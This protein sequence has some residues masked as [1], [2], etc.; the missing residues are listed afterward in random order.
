MEFRPVKQL[1]LVELVKKEIPLGWLYKWTH[2]LPSIYM[3]AFSE[4]KSLYDKP[5]AQDLI[6]YARRAKAEEVLRL[7]SDGYP[8]ATATVEKNCAHN[9]NYTQVRFGTLIITA[10]HVKHPD[11]VVRSARFRETLA[12]PNLQMHL[13]RSVEEEVAG[14]NTYYGILLHGPDIRDPRKPGFAY[15][16]FPSHDSASYVGKIDLIA[17]CDTNMKNIIPFQSEEVIDDTIP[18]WLPDA[19][20]NKDGKNGTES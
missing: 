12:R 2:S 16:A 14:L 17:F 9:W 7:I 15:L 19:V 13:F 10:S 18:T 5:E 8:Q 11:A 20:K 3:N 1:D 6:P 4:T